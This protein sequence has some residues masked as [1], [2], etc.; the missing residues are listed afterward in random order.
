MLHPLTGMTRERLLGKTH[1]WTSGS[2][3]TFHILSVSTLS[4][5]TY[6]SGHILFKHLKICTPLSHNLYFINIKNILLYK[7]LLVNCR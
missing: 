7:S 5:K 6:V 3:A 2:K 4:A 1:F